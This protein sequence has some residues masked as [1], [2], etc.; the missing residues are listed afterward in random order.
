M[1]SQAY[2][3]SFVVEE[4]LAENVNLSPKNHS[5]CEALTVAIGS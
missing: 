2:V 1:I 5:V 4:D 3:K